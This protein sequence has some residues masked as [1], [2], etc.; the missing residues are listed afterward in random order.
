MHS[1]AKKKI[2]HRIFLISLISIILGGCATT[3]NPATGRQESLMIGTEREVAIGRS[4]AQQVEEVFDLST[5]PAHITLVETIG[6][7]VAAVCERKDLNYYFKV[8]DDDELNAFALPGGYV[9][10][11]SGM[12]EKAGSNDEIACVLAHELGHIAAKHSVKQMQAAYGAG[13]GMTIIAAATGSSDFLRVVNVGVD[14]AMRGYSRKDELEADRLG[15]RY[16]YRAGYDPRAMITL[17]HRIQASKSQ[18]VEFTAWSTH[19][20]LPYRIEQAKIE[21]A[22]YPPRNSYNEHPDIDIVPDDVDGAAMEGE[23]KFCPECGRRYDKSFKYCPRDNTELK[24][25]TDY[26]GR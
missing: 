5:N 15:I 17:L 2:I 14:L 6:E 12:I 8:I 9:Y 13:I 1:G 18:A 4:G 10:V 20:A 16:T 23:F 7:E 24:W 21:I 3:Y 11:H 19:P 22:K 26:K 25:G